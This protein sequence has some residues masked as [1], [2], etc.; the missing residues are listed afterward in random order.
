MTIELSEIQ[1]VSK[2]EPDK[3]FKFKLVDNPSDDQEVL[4]KIFDS[5]IMVPK[6]Y[7]CPCLKKPKKDANKSKREFELEE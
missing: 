5:D 1:F 4:N 3:R 6:W 2:H 7:E